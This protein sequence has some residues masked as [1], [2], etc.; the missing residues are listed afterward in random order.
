[1]LSAGSRTVEFRNVSEA[2]GKSFFFLKE[3]QKQAGNQNK[4]TIQKGNRS[5]LPLC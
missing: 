2:T 4:S 1:M 5:V 3:K